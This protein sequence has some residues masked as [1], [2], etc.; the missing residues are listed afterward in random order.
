VKLL[1]AEIAHAGDAAFDLGT[2]LAHLA[3][4][5]LAR[6]ADAGALVARVRDAYRR[7]RGAGDALL[8]RAQQYGGFELIRRMIGAARVAA[9]AN[10]EASL[11]V[12]AAGRA[13]VRDS[14]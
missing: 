1:D 10:D 5:A 13:W 2:L 3:L 9:V 4:P 6:G 7:E 11:R 14:T 12:L 8:A